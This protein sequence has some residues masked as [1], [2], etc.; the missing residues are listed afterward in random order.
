[1]KTVSG[2]ELIDIAL[3][4]ARVWNHGAPPPANVQ[5]SFVFN[6]LLYGEYVIVP[7]AELR[8][9]VEEYH[10]RRG[11]TRLARILLGEIEE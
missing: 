5:K 10:P 1:M 7:K 6:E 2:R 3:E 11:E 4:K 9:V 8:R